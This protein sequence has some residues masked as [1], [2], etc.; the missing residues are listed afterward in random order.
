MMREVLHSLVLSSISSN[1]LILACPLGEKRKKA[2]TCVNH[3]SRSTG[4]E[5]VSGI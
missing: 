2:V 4:S 1:L 5:I 3:G